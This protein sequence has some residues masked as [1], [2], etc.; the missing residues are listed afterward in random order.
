MNDLGCIQHSPEWYAARIGMV[1]ASKVKDAIVK[2]KRGEGDLV[3]RRNL[4]LQMLAEILTGR[5]TDHYVSQAMDWGVEQEP[6]ARAEYEIRTGYSVEPL[7]LVLHPELSRAAASPDGFIPK[8][9]LLEIKC[10]ETYTHLEYMAEGVIPVDYLD[11]MDWQMACAGS[12]IEW[13]DF[14]SYDPR[15]KDDL[16]LFIVRRERNGKRIA[17]MEGL[18]MEFLEELNQMAEQV[19]RAAKGQSLESKLRESVKQARGRYPTDAELRAQL[20]DEVVP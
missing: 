12:E 9:G 5:T 15:L 14:V 2:R 11:Q 7:G 17:E 8:N 18:V 1:T 16:Q 4:K 13:C 6:R 3:A 19:T 10:P 20:A